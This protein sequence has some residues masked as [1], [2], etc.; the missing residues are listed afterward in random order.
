MDQCVDPPKTIFYG[1]IVFLAI[2]ISILYYFDVERRKKQ[3]AQLEAEMY[4]EERIKEEEEVLGLHRDGEIQVLAYDDTKSKQI[5]KV[6]MKNPNK[7]KP[8]QSPTHSPSSISSI[9]VCECSVHVDKFGILSDCLPS[10]KNYLLQEYMSQVENENDGNE[11]EKKTAKCVLEKIKIDFELKTQLAW[12]IYAKLKDTWIDTS[13]DE[14]LQKHTGLIKAME[15][16][17]SS[18][19][20][21]KL[22]GYVVIY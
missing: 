16:Q 19:F 18:P 13:F 22:I 2:A 8:Q 7:K 14:M 5:V 6:M 4:D 9:P 11:S 10:I 12:V 1:I 20:G 15:I 21:F 17:F 3:Y